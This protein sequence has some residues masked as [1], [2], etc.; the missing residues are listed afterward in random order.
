VLA[1]VV[2]V[3]YHNGLS[4]PLIFDDRVHIAENPHI[5]TLWPPAATLAGS[6]RPLITLSLALNYA[7]GGLEVAGYHAVN[8]AIH[9][10]AALTLFAILRRTLLMPR[11]PARDAGSATAVALAA[12]ALW[13]AHPLGTQAVTY[14]IQRGE[15]LA[16]LFYL[17]TLYG[18]IRGA[19][20]RGHAGAWHALA[21]TCCALGAL[22]KPV[23]VSA[24][25]VVLLY[26]R[27]FLAGSFRELLRRRWGLY[28]GL[29][30]SW[31]VTLAL[32]I[33]APDPSAGARATGVTALGYA[34][35]QPGVVLHYLR[36]ALWP[37]PLVL[38]Y[39]WPVAR[40]AAAVAPPALALAALVAA[41]AWAA[42]RGSALAFLG[43][44][45]FLVLAPSSSF[46]P[47]NDLAFEHRMYLPLAAVTTLVVVAADAWLARRRG[48]AAAL[49]ILAVI[50]ASAL[51]VRRNADYRSEISIW[52]DV[53]RKRPANPRG[54]NNLGR[55]FLR[56]NE[57]GRA[58]APLAEAVRLDPDYPEA[59]NNLGA[60]LAARGRLG[61]A[62]AEFDRALALAPEL[63]DARL[64]RGRALVRQERF[65]E[66]AE[67]LGELVQARP[68]DALAWNELGNALARLGRW[69]EA[70][71]CYARA[72]EE[73]PGLAEAHHNLG[74]LLARRGRLDDAIAR[75][76]EAL[77]RN[78]DFAPA[79]RSLRSALAA[80]ARSGEAAPPPATP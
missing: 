78:P 65:G 43:A 53:T 47:I 23:V 32:A 36:L 11:F 30:A 7:A 57:P 46:F 13:A 62:I 18:A 27:C 1:A 70:E 77:R 15:S 5:R 31:G 44:W 55:A 63:H 25:L 4:G 42:A 21:A 40:G 75:F 35:S 69:D 52:A 16:G 76:R 54:H 49:A 61:E 33:A 56:V 20:S 22:S 58:L 71:P 73:D 24:P 14:V 3:A 64:N 2:G 28:A 6:D 79:E 68:H 39:G 80:A 29:V 74:I 60:A 19:G 34:A 37:D 17:L 26:D 66:A 72:T 48:L 38:D 12:A 67:T 45:F 8:V 9:L 10:L 59:R 51:T 50:G 41:T